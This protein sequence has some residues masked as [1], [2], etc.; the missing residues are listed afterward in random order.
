MGV[1]G[2]PGEGTRFLYLVD[3]PME[4]PAGFNMHGYHMGSKFSEPLNVSLR[5]FDHE[6]DIQGFRGPAL[7]GFHDREA[8]ADI[9]YEYAIHDIDMEPVCLAVIDQV[10]GGVE[11][12]EI[13]G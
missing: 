6:V 12:A 8:K 2:Y 9:G 10:D 11:V 7:Q 13:S 5:R 4:V 3:H 1:D